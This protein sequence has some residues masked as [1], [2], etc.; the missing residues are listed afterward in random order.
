MI[1]LERLGYVLPG[2]TK[3]LQDIG[4]LILYLFT[5]VSIA[6]FTTSL[7]LA[8]STGQ[9]RGSNPEL[10]RT[11]HVSSKVDGWPIAKQGMSRNL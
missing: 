7:N 5:N 8:A 11:M 6:L 10:N 3:A 4:I 2:T 9:K 1:Y